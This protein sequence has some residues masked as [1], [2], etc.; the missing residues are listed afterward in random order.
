MKLL[1]L[2]TQPAGVALSAGT[3]NALASDMRDAKSC[4][5]NGGRLGSES[6]TLRE[7]MF[8]W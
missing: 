4:S 6:E 3:T 8:P 1:T 5:G 2:R 7:D